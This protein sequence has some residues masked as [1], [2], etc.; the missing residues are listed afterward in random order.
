MAIGQL[1]Y[2]FRYATCTSIK[3]VGHHI[4]FGSGCRHPHGQ[5]RVANGALLGIAV[6]LRVAAL[7]LAETVLVR[8]PTR[9]AQV[10]LVTHSGHLPTHQPVSRSLARRLAILSGVLDKTPYYRPSYHFRPGRR[11][12]SGLSSLSHTGRTCIPRHSSRPPTLPS[13]TST[14][15]ARRTR[16]TFPPP[17]WSGCSAFICSW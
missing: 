13:P 4:R 7:K 8:I 1:W 5:W 12:L 16:S 10:G 3:H 6:L 15:R 17:P 9:V 11:V 14:S 2:A